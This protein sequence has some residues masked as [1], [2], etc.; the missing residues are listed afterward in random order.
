MLRPIAYYYKQS[1]HIIHDVH[2]MANPIALW[3]STLAVFSLLLWLLLGKKG[4]FSPNNWIITYI[5]INYLA[6]LLPWIKVTRCI[7]F[8]HYIEAYTFS[9][10]ALAWFIDGWL[11]SSKI[12]FKFAGVLALA[13]ITLAFIFWLPIYLGSPLSQ[14]EFNQRM[15][16]Q[17]W[18]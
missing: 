2:S 12:V 10:L 14:D 4:L 17:S 6:N 7:F 5:V 3:L 1:N 8:Y 9:L 15:L 11:T 18:I 16:L 13:L